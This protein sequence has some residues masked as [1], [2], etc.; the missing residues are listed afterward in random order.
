MLDDRLLATVITKARRLALGMPRPMKRT[1][2]AAADICLVSAA[3]LAAWWIVYRNTQSAAMPWALLVAVAG[4]TVVFWV[5]GLYRS[6]T[7]FVDARL[8]VRVLRALLYVGVAGALLASVLSIGEPIEAAALVAVFTA[9][10]AIS[11][12]TVRLIVRSFLLRPRRGCERVLIY[13]A[14]Q[15]GIALGTNLMR[16]RSFYPVGF[17]DD[18]PRLQG[19]FISGLPVISPNDILRVVHREGVRRV[20]LALPTATRDR[21]REILDFLEGLPVRIQTMPNIHDLISGRSHL[22]ELR[23]VSVGD[24]LGRDPVKADRDIMRAHVHGKTILLTGAGGSIGSE[25]GRQLVVHEPKRILLFEQS[26]LALYNAERS[27]RKLAAGIGAETELVPLLGSVQDHQRV[28]S[29]LTTYAVDTVYHAAAYKHVPIV[30]HNISEG[31]RNNALGTRVVAEAARRH[32]VGVFVLVSTDKAVAPTSVMG[33][34]KRF[35]ELILQGM[36]KLEGKTKFCIVRFGNVLESSGSVVPLFREQIRSGGPV[37]VTDPEVTRYF[38]TIPEA[39]QLIIQAGAMGR[40]GDVFV[41]EMGQPVRIADLATRMIRL[42]GRTVKDANHPEGEVEIQYTGLRPG[43]KLHEELLIDSAVEHTDHPEIM[44]AMERSLSWD[45]VSMV[46][47]KMREALDSENLDE[48]QGLLASVVDG[49]AP[50]KLDDYLMGTAHASKPDGA[51]I[52]Y[53]SGSSPLRVVNAP[54]E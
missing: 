2:L 23:D 20:L 31:I 1:M 21:R 42:M 52:T 35:A 34:T 39:S 9:F 53:M 51:S 19:S 44:R 15:A 32:G 25:L 33:A 11:T 36:Q 26:E 16:Q 49:Y 22:A 28:D 46:I 47:E 13:G 6:I 7:R 48:V 41:L 18:D 40:G 14:G 38:M 4:T 17:V 5:Q 12:S 43:E 29:A 54:P 27:L 3:F 30:E 10:T 24:I 8:A 45:R 50:E 37:T